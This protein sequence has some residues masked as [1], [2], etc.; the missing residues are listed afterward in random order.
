MR[1]VLHEH[2]ADHED[3]GHVS[4]R[5]S[6]DEFLPETAFYMLY[7]WPENIIFFDTTTSI[8]DDV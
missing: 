5:I 7:G 4:R 8:L 6:S 1:R 3:V 2:A